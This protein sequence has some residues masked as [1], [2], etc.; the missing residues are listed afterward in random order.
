M[1][2]K[3][4]PIDEFSSIV[5]AI[6]TVVERYRDVYSDISFKGMVKSDYP[7][8]FVDLS[9]MSKVNLRDLQA[10]LVPFLQTELNKTEK[11]AKAIDLG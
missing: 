1:G 2:S 6:I 7:S 8:N 10:Q 11:E 3:V 5:D 9:N 4:T